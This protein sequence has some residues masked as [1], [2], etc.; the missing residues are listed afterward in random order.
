MNAATCE[1][2]VVNLAERRKIW[3]RRAEIIPVALEPEGLASLINTLSRADLEELAALDER[4]GQL[5]G[6]AANLWC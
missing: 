3:K 5:A 4:S 2:L 6:E 1:K